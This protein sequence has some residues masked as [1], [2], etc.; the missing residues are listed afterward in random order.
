MCNRPE[1]SS[2]NLSRSEVGLL[3]GDTA[4]V[5]PLVEPITQ[6]RG[7]TV[8]IKLSNK[9]LIVHDPLLLVFSTIFDDLVHLCVSKLLFGSY[10]TRTSAFRLIV[11]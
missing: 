6:G 8:K 3:A 11:L 2:E 4:I 1:E 5:A 7:S 9:D 10:S